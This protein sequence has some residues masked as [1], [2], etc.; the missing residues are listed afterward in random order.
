MLRPPL[1]HQDFNAA[2]GRLEIR[3][4]LAENVLKD[5]AILK[6]HRHVDRARQVGGV[7]IKLFEQC[8]QKFRR[9]ENLQVLPVK[10]APVH[11]AAAAQVK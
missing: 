11:H 4:A 1:R 3:R 6:V 7:E 2:A 5:R 10:I 9:L 8:G